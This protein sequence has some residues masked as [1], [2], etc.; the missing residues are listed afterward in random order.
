MT[1]WF[2]LALVMVAAPAQADVVDVVQDHI[3]RGYAAFAIAAQDLAREAD[4][5]CALVDLEAPYHAAFD[6][7]MAVQHLHLG[8]VEDEGRGLAIAFWPDPKG[9]GAKAQRILLA[10]PPQDLTPLFMAEQSV[11]ARGLTGLERLLWPASPLPGD[12]CP[13]IRATAQ[14]LARLAVAIEQG[15]QQGYADLLLTAGAADNPRFLSVDEA[16]QTLFTTLVTGLEQLETQRL[17][18]PLGT[19]DRPTPERAEARASGRSLHNVVLSLEALDHLVATL[20]PLAPETTKAMAR[21]IDLAKGLNDPIFAGAANPAGRL[22]I[23]ILQQAIA[24]ARRAA[25]A[26]IGPALGVG[27][28]FNSL[29]GD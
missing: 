24:S 7:W 13:L 3:L 20:T 23:E 27:L 29:D 9:L 28:G 22:R 14:D 18:R 15:W 6:R 19:F 8:P 17:G 4:N 11:A 21:A 1:R 25:V 2:M 26:E 16:R 5:S 10:T 12:P